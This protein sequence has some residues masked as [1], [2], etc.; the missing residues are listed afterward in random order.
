MRPGDYYVL[1]DNR[2]DE[3]PSLT[4][5]ASVTCREDPALP[6]LLPA[7]R[8]YLITAIS[9]TLFAAVA[10]WSGWRLRGARLFHR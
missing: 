5:H 7:S 1:I 8:R 10:G 3:R 4:V 2:L 9:L 6:G